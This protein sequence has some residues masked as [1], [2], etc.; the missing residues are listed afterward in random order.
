MIIISDL[1]SSYVFNGAIRWPA[2]IGHIR[3]PA[4]IRTFTV[5]HDSSLIPTMGIRDL[6]HAPLSNIIPFMW[7]RQRR[8]YVPNLAT[9]GP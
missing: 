1:M 8:S 4:S 3:D 7:Q 2:S 6:G 5:T 9:I